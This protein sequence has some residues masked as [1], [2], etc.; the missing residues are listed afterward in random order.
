M[1]VF[2]DKNYG[3]LKIAHSAIS[4]RYL[5]RNIMRAYNTREW[6]MLESK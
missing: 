6:W 1:I 2:R 5:K 3:G 4:L